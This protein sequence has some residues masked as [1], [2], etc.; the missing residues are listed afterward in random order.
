MRVS[1]L[2]IKTSSE[3]EPS[4]LPQLLLHLKAITPLCAFKK[5]TAT[6]GSAVWKMNRRYR[7]ETES[8][9]KRIGGGVMANHSA[10]GNES[11]VGANSDLT[12]QRKQ[13]TAAQ[14]GRETLK[15]TVSW[16]S[17]RSI[18]TRLVPSLWIPVS[19]RCDLYAEWRIIDV[20]SDKNLQ[21]GGECN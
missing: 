12:A 6:L 2:N 11:A 19:A 1:V 3:S 8:A 9:L 15:G 10:K 7:S 21:R 14:G 18:S 16:Y 20:G 5:C 4:S 13:P 17:Y